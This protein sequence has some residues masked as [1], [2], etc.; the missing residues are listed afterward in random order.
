MRAHNENIELAQKT[1]ETIKEQIKE[2]EKALRE[3]RALARSFKNFIEKWSQE[4][5]SEPSSTT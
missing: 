1:L 3:Q 5:D 4:T 2:L